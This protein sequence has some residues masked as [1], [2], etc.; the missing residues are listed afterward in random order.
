MVATATFKLTF[1]ALCW[2]NNIVAQK[3]STVVLQGLCSCCNAIYQIEF[4]S[5]YA[6]RKTHYSMWQLSDGT[7]V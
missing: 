6:V 5:L 2:S 3:I 1:A 7:W 4:D